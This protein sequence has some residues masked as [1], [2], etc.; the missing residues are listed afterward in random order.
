VAYGVAKLID[1]G[2][3]SHYTSAIIAFAGSL[4][5]ALGLSFASIGLT[6]RKS[7]DARAELLWNTALV[8]VI[9]DKTLLVDEVLNL[10]P[11]RRTRLRMPVPGPR[12]GSRGDAT[13]GLARFARRV[14]P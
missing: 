5:G 13:A 4:A 11:P 10:A 8:E 3:A 9:S 1:S 6:V 14:A 2:E 12:R 7:L